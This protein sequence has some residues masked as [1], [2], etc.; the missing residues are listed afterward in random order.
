VVSL[1]VCLPVSIS[2]TQISVSRLIKS[3]M[4]KL[5]VSITPMNST[6][7]CHHFNLSVLLCQYYYLFAG[8]SLLVY[9]AVVDVALTFTVLKFFYLLVFYR[10]CSVFCCCS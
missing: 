3:V 9:T 2:V 5:I 1:S 7:V 10:H 6:A 4:D 8:F